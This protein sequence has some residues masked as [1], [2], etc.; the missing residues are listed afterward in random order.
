VHK[1]KV[2]SA[3]PNLL[4]APSCGP[5]QRRHP[6]PVPVWAVLALSPVTALLLFNVS[7]YVPTH[8]FAAFPF[9][10][11]HPRLEENRCLFTPSLATTVTDL[12]TPNPWAGPAEN[13][14]TI[15]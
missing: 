2:L 9:W 10:H 13:I 6:L 14:A 1:N 11:I 3:H 12:A 7:N 15:G 4:G 5:C 8:T